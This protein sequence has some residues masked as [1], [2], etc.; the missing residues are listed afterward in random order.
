MCM[1]QISGCASGDVVFRYD[2]VAARVSLEL[3][4]GEF[5]PRTSL[6]LSPSYI[7]GPP[8][9]YQGPCVHDRVTMDAPDMCD[10]ARHTP[11]HTKRPHPAAYTHT[12]LYVVYKQC[13]RRYSF[14]YSVGGVKPTN[15]QT[16]VA[17]VAQACSC[18]RT[19]VVGPVSQPGTC[20]CTCSPLQ[21]DK[22]PNS[23][24]QL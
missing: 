3:T 23:N 20:H 6:K 15:R 2:V 12:R 8:W 24:Y 11:T 14:C 13:T 9:S 22:T 10:I 21:A 1:L 17:S 7:P 16:P 18:P 4:Q 19:L 5:G